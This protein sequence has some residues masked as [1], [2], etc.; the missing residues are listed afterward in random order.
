MNEWKGLGH[1]MSV[2][3]ESWKKKKNNNLDMCISEYT[4]QKQINFTTMIRLYHANHLHCMTSGGQANIY[5]YCSPQRR[6][7]FVAWAT[8]K[9]LNTL[10]SDSLSYLCTILK[11][12]SIKTLWHISSIF[13][14]QHS[15]NIQNALIP[16]FK[17]NN[18]GFCPF[19]INVY[20]YRYSDFTL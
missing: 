7:S 9:Y 16:W 10:L 5:K 19:K 8:Q 6:H 11:Y 18:K 13:I 12:S 4:R 3:P 1:G 2:P 14:W 20:L 17:M 15:V